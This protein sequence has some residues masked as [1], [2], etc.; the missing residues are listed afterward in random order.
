MTTTSSQA[1]ASTPSNNQP[2]CQIGDGQV[3][4]GNGAECASVVTTKSAP[5]S[6]PSN[7]Q[8]VCQINDGQVQA[9]NAAECMST[10][11]ST[12]N[13]PPPSGTPAGFPP[14]SELYGTV[15]TM[16]GPSATGYGAPSVE[17]IPFSYTVPVTTR[18]GHSATG[19]SASSGA[20]TLSIALSSP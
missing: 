12:L 18:S 10:L 3:Q 5:A 7:N 2:V 8:P 20:S 13:V 16:S 19:Y 1:P 4:A 11:T 14:A 9:G 6:T 17:W 15:I